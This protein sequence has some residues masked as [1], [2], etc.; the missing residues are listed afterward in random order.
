MSRKIDWTKRN[1][2]L[3]GLNGYN[4]YRKENTQPPTEEQLKYIDGLVAKLKAHGVD[5]DFA[6][7][8][9]SIKYRRCAMET[10]HTLRQLMSDNGLYENMRTE[11]I[12]LCRHKETGKKIKYRTTKWCAAPVGYEFLG[13]LSKEIKYL[14]ETA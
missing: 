5:A 13:M 8:P 6:V 12:N 7:H 9:R 2:M 1:K 11:Y 10:I 4:P 3:D 14:E